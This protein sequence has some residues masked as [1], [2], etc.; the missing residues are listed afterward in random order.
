MIINAIEKL[1]EFVYIY[2]TSIY[3]NSFLYIFYIYVG[4]Y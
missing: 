1:A 2:M 3:Y 4:Y